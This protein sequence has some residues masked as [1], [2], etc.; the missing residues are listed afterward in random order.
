[1]CSCTNMETVGV[2]GLARTLL[3]FTTNKARLEVVGDTAVYKS[4]LYLLTY[5]LLFTIVS[6]CV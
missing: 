1:L 6:T 2:K 5:L 3:F 4:T